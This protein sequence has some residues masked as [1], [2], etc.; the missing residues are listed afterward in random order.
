[1]SR[2]TREEKAHRY[3]LEGKVKVIDHSLQR[4]TAEFEVY[5]SS[6]DPYVVRFG[7]VGLWHCDCPAKVEDCAHMLAC[8]LISP[9]TH[10]TWPGHKVERSEIDN[11]LGIDR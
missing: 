8:K 11:L 6:E 1:M 5:G 4:G 2:E 10:A 7:G 9:L 3:L